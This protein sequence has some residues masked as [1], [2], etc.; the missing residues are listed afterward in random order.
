MHTIEQ[1]T[2]VAACRI[3][4]RGPTMPEPD[5]TPATRHDLHVLEERLRAANQ[6]DLAGLETRLMAGLG[7]HVTSLREYFNDLLRSFEDRYRQLPGEVV[8]VKQELVAHASDKSIHHSH[9]R[10]P[11]PA[12]GRSR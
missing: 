10:K 2:D 6:A 7:Q 9:K 8:A 1:G 11:T 12:S 3:T 4:P 5:M